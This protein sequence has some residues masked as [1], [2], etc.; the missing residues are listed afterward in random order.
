MLWYVLHKRTSVCT[1]QCKLTST[2]NLRERSDWGPK[3][4]FYSLPERNNGMVFYKGKEQNRW[5]FFCHTA[6]EIFQDC[7]LQLISSSVSLISSI[8]WSTESLLKDGRLK[9]SLLFFMFCLALLLL[10]FFKYFFSKI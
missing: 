1:S 2:F 3:L 4:I 8:S 7:I 6:L 5:I 9:P 10:C